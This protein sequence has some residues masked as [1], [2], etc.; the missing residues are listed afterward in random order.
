[1]YPRHS[2]D[3]VTHGL[4]LIIVIRN[5][6]FFIEVETSG[7]HTIEKESEMKR[8][9]ERERKRGR[10]K[11]ESICPIYVDPDCKSFERLKVKEWLIS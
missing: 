9:R 1:L 4:I 8:E 7:R 3:K 5:Y 11:N 2:R 10:K 6:V